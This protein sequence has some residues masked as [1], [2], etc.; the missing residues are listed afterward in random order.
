MST[1]TPARLP[2][3]P[4]EKVWLRA[5][6]DDELPPI[7][8]LSD[9]AGHYQHLV[10]DLTTGEFFFH[11]EDWRVPLQQR[12]ENERA[13][14]FPP[15]DL[16]RVPARI[17]WMI[18]SSDP[19]VVPQLPWLDAAAGNALAARVLPYAQALVA[20]LRPIPGR[21]ELDW[22]A[23]ALR[24][25]WTVHDLCRR[26]PVEPDDSVEW[27]G[28]RD[29]DELL[30]V[31]PDALDR[32][33]SWIG[34]DG[35]GDATDDTIEFVATHFA[36]GLLFEYV[37]DMLPGVFDRF[38]WNGSA[39]GP[40]RRTV[41]GARAWLYGARHAAHG[42]MKVCD[43]VAWFSEWP[44]DDV[45]G[46][47]DAHD[48]ELPGWVAITRDRWRERGVHLTGLPAWAS[49]R[50]RELRDAY[51]TA[52]ASTARDAAV[53][54]AGAQRRV[55]LRN[56]GLHVVFSWGEKRDNDSELGRLLGL[57]HT[58]VGNVRRAGIA[59]VDVDPA[60]G[61]PELRYGERVDATVYRDD[62]GVLTVVL[63]ADDRSAGRTA[64]E[65]GVSGGGT[66]VHLVDAR[67]A[68]AGR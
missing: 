9:R 40:H 7:P 68:P 17:S 11:G 21:D 12:L 4:P 37:D 10:L 18:D 56:A 8:H 65:D 25:G 33:R 54:T 29:I 24:A 45:E 49:L 43:A 44:V 28:L 31:R 15:F 1:S 60:A 42:G 23:A 47:R 48:D 35:I 19:E 50:R 67:P 30:D 38:G 32:I 22:S 66:V 41:A 64:A 61:L 53:A 57:S 6:T 52:L 20:G 14:H 27:T 26:D 55:A 2:A 16:K 62:T 3:A 36:R 13:E 5:V 58:T 34:R 63:G 39:H 46:L 51:R 59:A